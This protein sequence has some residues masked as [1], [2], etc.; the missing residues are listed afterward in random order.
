MQL[1]ALLCISMLKHQ[2]KWKYLYTIKILRIFR[3]TKETCEL[4]L[5]CEQIKPKSLADHSD[6]L[7]KL[8]WERQGPGLNGF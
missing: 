8:H 5:K 4:T 3:I 6:M 2:F 1:F 7:I